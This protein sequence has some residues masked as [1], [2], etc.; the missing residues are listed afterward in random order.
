MKISNKFSKRRKKPIKRL[1][2]WLSDRILKWCEKHPEHWLSV[3]N[4]YEF[5]SDN[6]IIKSDVVVDFNNMIVLE[7]VEK[8]YL[9]DFKSGISKLLKKNKLKN[10]L[11][12]NNVDRIRDFI[13]EVST[14]YNIGGWSKL[15]YINFPDDNT[16]SNNIDYV[17]ICA[18]HFSPSL[19][20]IYFNIKVTKNYIEEINNIL[21]SNIKAQ[22]L[23][24]MPRIKNLFKYKIWGSGVISKDE[25]KNILIVDIITELKYRVL[26]EVNRYMPLY[27]T[28]NNILAPSLEVFNTNINHNAKDNHHCWNSLGID[29]YLGDLDVNGEWGLFLNK[30]KYNSD[31]FNFANYKLIFNVKTVESIYHDKEHY[32]FLLSS[33]IVKEIYPVLLQDTYINHYE[34]CFSKLRNK[35]Y[36]V[37][38]KRNISYRKLLKYRYKY[39]I[40]IKMFKRL[41]REFNNKRFDK[42]LER[43]S[44]EVID[45]NSKFR[46]H[47]AINL[48]YKSTLERFSIL[49]AD[50]EEI[51]NIIYQNTEL[52]TMKMNY[53]L[54]SKNLILTIITVTASTISVLIGL[55]AIGVTL[56]LMKV[57][58]IDSLMN[59]IKSVFRW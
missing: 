9:D 54:S 53:K 59:F 51:R 1:Q 40:D 30:Y 45:F 19:I 21:L 48:I 55:K 24:S 4:M 13:D 8:E 32:M 57:S 20:A 6:S 47:K 23:F 5:E 56:D 16:L 27:F 28:A 42:V 44:K 58:K 52:A 33:D 14:S 35:I 11:L 43:F 10:S 50:I 26:K 2:T 34:K 18:L 22:R 12:F 29:N 36:K 49:D 37:I 17:E 39:E 38:G 46:K 31:N 41:Y 3:D 25:T 7:L 15:G